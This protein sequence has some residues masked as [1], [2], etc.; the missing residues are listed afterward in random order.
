MIVE[1]DG[2][3]D[4]S[5]PRAK[6][7]DKVRRL[8]YRAM[9][10]RVV[11]IHPNRLRDAGDFANQVARELR[12]RATAPV[13]PREFLRLWGEWVKKYGDPNERGAVRERSVST[14]TPSG[15]ERPRAG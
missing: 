15:S 14:A 10:L 2:P 4:H 5:T 13:A 7:R 6:G 11:E 1:I 8:A 12:R 9:G 3:I